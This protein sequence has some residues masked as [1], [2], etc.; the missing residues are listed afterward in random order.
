MIK[1]LIK[2][3]ILAGFLLSL[4][5]NAQSYQ[6]P[7]IIAATTTLIEVALKDA[8]GDEMMNYQIIRIIPPHSCPGHF[9]LNPGQ[10]PAL[11]KA[12]MII[13]HSY[14]ETL[15]EKMKGI[16]IDPDRILIIDSKNSLLIPS[17]Y[18]TFVRTIS[19]SIANISRGQKQNILNNITDLSKRLGSLEE[20]IIISRETFSKNRVI[21]SAMQKDFC[22]YLGFDIIGTFKRAEDMS[23]ADVLRLISLDADMVIANLQEGTRAAGNISEKMGLPLAVLSNFPDFFEYGVNYL[24]LVNRNIDRLEESCRVNF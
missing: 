12:E 1:I 14:Q 8:L 5:F 24:E 16:G 18:L 13:L 15:A 17:N 21:V 7:G 9:D 3:L 2:V 4:P 20:R 19:E 10:L 23:P 6:E 11:K 22:Q